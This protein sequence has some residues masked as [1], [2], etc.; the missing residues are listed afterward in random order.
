MNPQYM[1]AYIHVCSQINTIPT[2]LQPD[3]D[4]PD[5]SLLTS[6]K[7]YCVDIFNLQVMEVNKEWYA[8]IQTRNYSDFYTY[9]NLYIVLHIFLL[10]CLTKILPV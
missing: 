6:F 3:R 4:F 5:T 9:F 2:S 10:I 7:I 1:N 8:T